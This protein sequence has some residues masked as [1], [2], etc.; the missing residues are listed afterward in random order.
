MVFASERLG[1]KLAAGD[2]ASIKVD[3]VWREAMSLEIP[4]N[5]S[6]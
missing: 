5:E 4:N 1:L 6:L 2:A 3:F